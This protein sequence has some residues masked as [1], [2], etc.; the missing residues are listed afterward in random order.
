MILF[1]ADYHTPEAG[2]TE[3][4]SSNN[5]K[6]QC[7]HIFRFQSVRGPSLLKLMVAGIKHE[8][9]A[10]IIGTELVVTVV[11]CWFEIWGYNEAVVSTKQKITLI[12]LYS[13]WLI[14]PGIMATDNFLRVCK[15]VDP[16]NVEKGK[17]E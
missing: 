15:R 14:I 12:A 1:M 13:P 7:G 10:I 5:C 4:F 3:C 11:L 2:S 17:R 6:F 16:E 9:W 8:L